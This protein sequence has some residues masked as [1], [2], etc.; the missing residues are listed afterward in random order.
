MCVLIMGKHLKISLIYPGISV[1]ERYGRD[2]GDIGG[3]QAPLG[4][5]Y[6]SSYLKSKGF[7]TQVIDAEALSLSS[8]SIIEKLANADLL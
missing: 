4:L 2:I 1:E 7:E 8:N 3:K 6:L 5:L